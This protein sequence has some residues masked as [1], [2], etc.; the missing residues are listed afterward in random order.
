MASAV[1]LISA[2]IVAKHVICSSITSGNSDKKQRHIS[3]GE[4]VQFDGL[5]GGMIYD[6][7]IGLCVKKY[8][9]D[10]DIPMVKLVLSGEINLADSIVVPEYMVHRFAIKQSLS[11]NG[12]VLSEDDRN[13]IKAIINSTLQRTHQEFPMIALNLCFGQIAQKFQV[14][15]FYYSYNVLLTT[16]S[17][18][19]IEFTQYSKT[20]QALGNDSSPAYFINTFYKKY[21]KF[22]HS[23]FEGPGGLVK[24]KLLK[25]QSDNKLQMRARYLSR[26]FGEIIPNLSIRHNSRGQVEYPIQSLINP[27]MKLRLRPK[28]L[29]QIKQIHIHESQRYSFPNYRK[30]MHELLSNAKNDVLYL[31]HVIRN[32]SISA[33]I[34]IFSLLI[35]QLRRRGKYSNLLSDIG[36]SEFLMFDRTP[37]SLADWK[38]VVMS[39]P[40]DI[41]KKVWERVI[42]FM[43]KKSHPDDRKADKALIKANKEIFNRHYDELMKFRLDKIDDFVSPGKKLAKECTERVEKRIGKSVRQNRIFYDQLFKEIRYEMMELIAEQHPSYLGI[44]ESQDSA[45]DIMT[46]LYQTSIFQNYLIANAKGH[47]LH[48]ICSGFDPCK[49]WN[50]KPVLAERLNKVWN[51]NDSYVAGILMDRIFKSGRENQ[52]DIR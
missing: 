17:E 22:G 49:L 29:L 16:S 20:T 41:S 8:N 47:D 39:L 32:D 23:L 52:T 35:F 26:S 37:K 12:Y 9:N 43:K 45:F 48:L 27:D 19:Y 6:N 25:N 18:Q 14:N 36:M 13:T 28:Y 4:L 21:L 30:L 33:P 11:K 38:S 15:G 7:Q 2:C 34:D 31:P 5:Y 50:I 46:E 40:F 10:N 51:I 44:Y 3:C 24:I 1:L 42:D